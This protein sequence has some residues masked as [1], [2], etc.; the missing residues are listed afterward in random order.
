MMTDRPQPRPTSLTE[1]F[2]AAAGRHELV[3]Q[4]CVCGVYRHYPQP[5]CPECLSRDWTW[6]PVRGSGVIH[7][8]TVTHRA[9]HPAWADRVPYVVAT[10]ELDEG[11]RMVSD[12]P[13]EDTELAAVGTAVEVFFDDD[14]PITLPRFRVV[15][16]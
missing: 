11:V 2:W 12:L 13:A 4:Q 3:V 9:F 6:T 5:L 7:S 8:F 16:S 15:R 10:V 14:G 1:E